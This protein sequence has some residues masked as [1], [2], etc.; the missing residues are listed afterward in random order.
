M[1]QFLF[2]FLVISV[3][4]CSNDLS[5]KNDEEG[6]QTLPGNENMGQTIVQNRSI[7]TV[8][9][10]GKEVTDEENFVLKV[11]VLTVENGPNYESLATPGNDY[12]LKPAFYFDE[13]KEIPDNEQNMGALLSLLSLCHGMVGTF[14]SPR[15]FLTSKAIGFL[16]QVEGETVSNK[17]SPERLCLLIWLFL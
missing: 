8:K 6:T 10:I 17:V 11:T 2:L 9:L 15:P 1:K 12:E 16:P 7:V 5:K 4:S 3:I 14:T 13:N